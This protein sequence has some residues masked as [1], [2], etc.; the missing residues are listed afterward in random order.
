MRVAVVIIGGGQAGLAMSHCLTER[1]IEHVVLERGVVANSWRTE[2]WDSL[3]LLTPNWMS[4]LPG[5]GYCGEDPDGFMTK[6]EVIAFLDRYGATIAAPVWTDTT[7]ERVRVTGDG[8]SVETNR[9]E[10]RCAAVVIATGAS[11]EPRIPPIAADLPSRINQVNALEYRNPDQLDRGEVLVVGAS[12]S[13]AQ[14]AD[15]LR[16][17]GR[18]VTLAVGDHVRL[19]RRYRG[20]DIHW[21]MDAIGQLDERYDEVED[22]TRARR[23][24]SLQLI[25]S[26]ENRTL[27]LDALTSTGVELVGRFMQVAGPQAQFSGALGHLVANADLKQNRLLDRIDEFAESCGLADALPAPTRPD[28]TRIGSVPTEIPIER[29]ASVVWATG[30]RPGYSWLDTA[31]FDHRGRI[32]HDGGRCDLPGLY[33]MGQPFMRRRKSSFIDGVGPDAIELAE[34]LHEHLDS[35]ATPSRRGC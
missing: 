15:E 18:P 2:R 28:R 1:S 11:S 24:P 5:Y 26:P 30:Y 25:G 20:R 34:S 19:P 16:R 17:S 31:A 22:L 13:G 10:W 4:R 32:A 14:I 7:V 21:W 29:F 33:L 3:R 8:F 12:A 27:D 35:L 6:D 9:G 23:L